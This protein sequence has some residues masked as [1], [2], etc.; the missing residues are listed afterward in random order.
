M[1]KTWTLDLID[2]Y[3]KDL[4]TAESL[5]KKKQRTTNRPPRS[6][7]TRGPEPKRKTTKVAKRINQPRPGY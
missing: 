1:S 5:E 7:K 6:V 4:M 3:L 2:Q